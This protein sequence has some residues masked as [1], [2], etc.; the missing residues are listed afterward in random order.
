MKTKLFL[1]KTVALLFLGLFSNFLLYIKSISY[2][3]SGTLQT[4]SITAPITSVCNQIGEACSDALQVFT[5]F[6]SSK[7][8]VVMITPISLMRKGTSARGSGTINM[9][10]IYETIMP[11]LHR[12]KSRRPY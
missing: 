12:V 6:T 11:V 1:L 5:G 2:S 3:V 8:S 9:F 10:L 7:P 4:F